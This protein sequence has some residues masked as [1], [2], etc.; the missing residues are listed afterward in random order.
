MRGVLAFSLCVGTPPR[1][2][3]S[4]FPSSLHEELMNPTTKRMLRLSAV[5]VLAFLFGVTGCSKSGKVTGTVKLD[6]KIIPIGTIT[7]H[8]AKGAAVSAE[9]ED[10]KYTVEKVPPGECTV[11]VDTSR[12]RNESKSAGKEGP[13]GMAMPPGVKMPTPGQ[14]APAEMQDAMN[15]GKDQQKERLAR[16]KNMIDVPKDFGDP[17]TSGL[18]Y[19]IT[20][21][22]QEID[23]DLK[24]KK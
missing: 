11:T 15:Q 24:P 9:I 3:V 16:L 21:G 17:K 22:S 20:S 13:G 14:G 19:T 8:P 12:Y 7:F 5:F 2:V 10:G 1:G 6:G 4:P 18:T 23:I